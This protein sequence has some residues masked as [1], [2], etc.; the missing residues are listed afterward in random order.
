MG[1][2]LDS[3]VAGF[4]TLCCILCFSPFFRIDKFYVSATECFFKFSR[5]KQTGK[6]N[7]NRT[8]V[9][10]LV[11][12]DVEFSSVYGNIT[13]RNMFIINCRDLYYIFVTQ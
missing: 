10:I 9:K 11:E 1:K 8:L 3:F 4:S 2:I 7:P 12:L 13:E 5:T 6:M